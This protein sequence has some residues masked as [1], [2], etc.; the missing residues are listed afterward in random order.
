MRQPHD[1][2]HRPAD[3]VALPG[4]PR[5]DAE[6]L[7]VRRLM[8]ATSPELRHPWRDPL[9]TIRLIAESAR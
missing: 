7:L 3:S 5:A 1:A 8:V 2:P 9:V 4:I 6:T